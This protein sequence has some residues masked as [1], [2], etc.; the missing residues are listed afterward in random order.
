MNKKLIANQVYQRLNQVRDKSSFQ[1]A[2]NIISDV[3][4]NEKEEL[5]LLDIGCATGEFFASCSQ[6]KIRMVGWDVDD[7]LL[8]V[9]KKRKLSNANFEKL[10]LWNNSIAKDQ[11]FDII[12]C[13]AVS[14]YFN[15]EEE[16]FTPLINLMSKTKLMLVHGLFN[17][18]GLTVKLEWR[19]D[20]GFQ[21]GLSQLNYSRCKEILNDAG[22]E[23]IPHRVRVDE[24]IK[25]DPQHPHRAFSVSKT[26]YTLMNGANLI[27]P[28]YMLEIKPK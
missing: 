22:L 1:I 14:G 2:R 12:C 26:D 27:L 17:M 7:D 16:F 23:V 11:R 5:T 21:P 18:H 8:E 10:D 24:L 20:G 13:F 19:K 3:I 6:L 28:D 15:D 4:K 9:A 25:F